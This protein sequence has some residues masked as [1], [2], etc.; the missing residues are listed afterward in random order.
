MAMNLTA[1]EI[2]NI[3]ALMNRANI[4]GQEALTVAGLQTKLQAMLRVVT[5]PP[6]IPASTAEKGE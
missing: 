6:E 3:L 2:K 1:E 4:T 5:A